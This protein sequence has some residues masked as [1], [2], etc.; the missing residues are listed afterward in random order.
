MSRANVEWDRGENKNPAAHI[1]LTEEMAYV[2]LESSIDRLASSMLWATI[3]WN[4][5]GTVQIIVVTGFI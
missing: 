5:A 1:I 2:Y 4:K 3:W